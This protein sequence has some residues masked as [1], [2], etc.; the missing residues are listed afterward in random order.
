MLQVA[1]RAVDITIS[2]CKFAWLYNIVVQLAHDQ[3]RETIVREVAAQV[4]DQLPTT[5]NAVLAV[6]SHLGNGLCI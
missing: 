3:V 4:S 2:G 5:G 6:R 1:F